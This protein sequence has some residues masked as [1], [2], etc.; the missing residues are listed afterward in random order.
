MTQ[1]FPSKHLILYADDDKDDIKLVEEAFSENIL[2][3]E[4]VAV[5]NGQ[6]AIDYLDHLSLFDANPCL[7]I[8][9][10]NMPRLDGKETLLQIRQRDR[11]KN[12]PVVLFSTSSLNNDKIF[13]ARHG[14][15]FITKP[16][17]SRQLQTITD[18]FIDHCDDEIKRNIH[19]RFS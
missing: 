17:N 1:A 6:Q 16:L 15:G 14:A 8:L 7:I 4:L 11:F 2:N 3:V 18:Q 19:R 5:E 12:T 13:A 10:I 9:D